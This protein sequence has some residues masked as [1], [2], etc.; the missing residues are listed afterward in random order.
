[1]LRRI[2]ASDRSGGKGASQI[3]QFHSENLS[4]HGLI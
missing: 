4:L 3:Q 1:L 2:Q